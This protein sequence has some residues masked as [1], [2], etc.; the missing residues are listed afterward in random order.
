MRRSLTHSDEDWQWR[1]RLATIAYLKINGLLVHNA[2][3]CE[4]DDVHNSINRRCFKFYDGDV[5]PFV[6]W[7]MEDDYEAVPWLTINNKVIIP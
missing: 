4:D 3:L 5:K 7:M 1:L 6:S 2:V